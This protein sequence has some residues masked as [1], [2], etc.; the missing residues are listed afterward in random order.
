VFI[1]VLNI[2]RVTVI[3]RRAALPANV[4]TIDYGIP[5]LQGNVLSNQPF[6]YFVGLNL[7]PNTQIKNVV[8]KIMGRNTIAM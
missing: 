4:S 2:S 6:A 5:E 1:V 3:K 7:S 8:V